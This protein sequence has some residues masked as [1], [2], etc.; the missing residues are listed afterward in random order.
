[1]TKFTTALPS[2]GAILV[3]VVKGSKEGRHGALAVEV[4]THKPKAKWRILYG[5][6]EFKT[7]TSAAM[8]IF[9]ENDVP[10]FINR[11]C[12]GEL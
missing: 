1:L 9:S 8:S 6:L 10:F 3:P 5:N 4:K 11:E 2:T 12:E 7:Q